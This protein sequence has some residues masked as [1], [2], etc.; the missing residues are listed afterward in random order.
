MC[1][2]RREQ[3]SVGEDRGEVAAAAACAVVWCGVMAGS[4]MVYCTTV[5]GVCA[6]CY[7]TAVVCCKIEGRICLPAW[8]AGG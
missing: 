3:S 6:S 8:C 4:N 1:V 7:V 2:Y 5:A